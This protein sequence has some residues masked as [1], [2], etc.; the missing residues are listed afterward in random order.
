MIYKLYVNIAGWSQLDFDFDKKSI[1]DTMVCDNKLQK[2]T[3]YKIVS[4]D[5]QKPPMIPTESITLRSQEEIDQ[6][7]ATY[8]EQQELKNMSILDLKREIVKNTPI[9]TLKK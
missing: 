9:K 3:C 1:I 6:Y 5:D 2:H 8:K 4:E 7:I